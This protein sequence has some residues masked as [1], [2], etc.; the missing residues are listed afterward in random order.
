MCTLYANRHMYCP[1][2]KNYNIFNQP[3]YHTLTAMVIDRKM[4][5]PVS[6]ILGYPG[7]IPLATSTPGTVS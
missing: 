5:Y 6:I 2:Y 7:V 1:F 4:T 3:F